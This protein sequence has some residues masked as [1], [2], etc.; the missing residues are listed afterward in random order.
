M[1]EKTFSLLLNE[2]DDKKHTYTVL[3]NKQGNHI[4]S[5]KKFKNNF[6]N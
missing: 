1:T 6:K 5:E 2:Y 4:R 3:R